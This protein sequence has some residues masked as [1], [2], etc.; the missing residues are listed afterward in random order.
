MTGVYKAT[1]SKF[2]ASKKLLF[3]KNGSVLNVL[4]I[5]AA[6]ITEMEITWFKVIWL[7]LAVLRFMLCILPQTG[8]IFPD[9]FF[10]SPEIAAGDVFG[11]MNHLTWEWNAA[12]PAR[13]IIFPVISSGIPFL[14][15]KF[16]KLSF[17]F[18]ITPY[19][20][21]LAPRLWMTLLSFILDYCIY[22]IALRH[23]TDRALAHTSVFIFASSYTVW[24]Y[25]TR[26]FSNATELMFVA[27]LLNYCVIPSVNRCR[28]LRQ[29][30]EQYRY[31]TAKLIGAILV[32]GFFIRTSFVA[33]AVIPTLYWIFPDFIRE[34]LVQSFYRCMC[35]AMLLFMPVLI[36]CFFFA[37]CDCMYFQ[38]D[39]FS[40]LAVI[41]QN[42][43]INSFVR[44]MAEIPWT[45]INIMQY[46]LKNS[47]LEKHGL[48][49]WYLHTLVNLPMLFGP[50]LLVFLRSCLL[51]VRSDK[52]Q[53]IKEDKYQ[54]SLLVGTFL[55]GLVLLSCIPHQ[56]PRYILPLIVPLCVVSAK[57]V[58]PF[59]MHKLLT[60]LWLCFNIV[61]FIAFGIIHQGGMLPCMEHLHSVV[62]THSEMNPSGGNH[63]LNIYFYKTYM[64]PVHLL[65]WPANNPNLLVNVVDLAGQD[66]NVLE[67]V[68]NSS[69]GVT[70]NNYLVYPASLPCDQHAKLQKSYHLELYFRFFP[71]LSGENLPNL[72]NDCNGNIPDGSY[73]LKV[74]NQMSLNLYKVHSRITTNRKSVIFS[75]ANL[76]VLEKQSVFKQ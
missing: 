4:P 47:N 76:N 52:D 55:C 59:Q 56:E 15:L 2:H 13:T 74:L 19:L 34:N 41:L 7:H 63:T 68:I 51:S 14:F 61:A 18:L 5:S 8:Y 20:L 6:Q 44:W 70:E 53:K 60:S 46:N 62:K 30:I 45:P 27:I 49:P 58:H 35:N 38:P 40:Q 17:G 31:T 36:T 57:A 64:P 29:S 72:N 22:Q 16:L 33:F 26:T 75:Q 11:Y 69:V 24:V 3:A 50:L 71:H 10:Q 39:K 9:E 12:K 43:D 48:H 66:L 67:K 65:A 42:L 25:C 54:L 28:L 73:F 37:C 32:S 23:Y 1:S 21:L